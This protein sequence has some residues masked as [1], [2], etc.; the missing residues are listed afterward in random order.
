MLRGILLKTWK[1]SKYLEELKGKNVKI[2]LY[3]AWY[4]DSEIEE[5][6]GYVPHPSGD[7]YW[8]GPY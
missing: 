5:M 2:G 6:L 4:Q 3:S 8:Q 1:N 7:I